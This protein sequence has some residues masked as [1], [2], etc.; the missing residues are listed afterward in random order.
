MN[1][2][3]LQLRFDFIF[4]YVATLS[5]GYFGRFH[6]FVNNAGHLSRGFLQL[7]RQKF[8]CHGVFV[9]C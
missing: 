9:K 3:K 4:F 7:L 2:F 6:N 1:N 5:L 8:A